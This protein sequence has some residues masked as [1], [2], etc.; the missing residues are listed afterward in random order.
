MGV[1]D[2]SVDRYIIGNKRICLKFFNDCKYIFGGVGVRIKP[3][4]KIFFNQF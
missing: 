4:L 1:N 2:K 3:N